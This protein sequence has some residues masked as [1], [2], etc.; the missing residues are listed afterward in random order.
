MTG[1]QIVASGSFWSIH[2]FWIPD[3]TGWMVQFRDVPLIM[4]D[5]CALLHFGIFDQF[6]QSSL[7]VAGGFLCRT[8]CHLRSV[9]VQLFS[10]REASA[11][12]HVEAWLV[13]RVTVPRWLCLQFRS[14]CLMGMKHGLPDDPRVVDDF[15]MDC[16]H[17]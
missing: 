17:L 6:G 5:S 12:G 11:G 13:I 9:K 3:P 1:L 8:T 10:I 4:L 14:K 16:A 15:S 2:C 7:V